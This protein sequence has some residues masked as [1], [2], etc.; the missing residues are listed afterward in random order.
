M[1]AIGRQAAEYLLSHRS[2]SRPVRRG[3]GLATKSKAFRYESERRAEEVLSRLIAVDAA[4][5]QRTH[6]SDKRGGPSMLPCDRA[7]AL[8]DRF[9]KLSVDLIFES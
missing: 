4:F 3:Q 8:K 6:G 9:F 2:R 1:E 7:K 5:C